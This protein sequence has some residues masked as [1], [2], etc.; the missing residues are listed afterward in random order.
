MI[1]DRLGA[2]PCRCSCRS[3]P[4]DNFRGVVDLIRMKAIYWDD[5]ATRRGIVRG[6]RHPGGMRERQGGREKMIEAA[7]EVDEELMH[8][9]LEGRSSRPTRSARRCARALVCNEIVPRCCGSAFKNKGVQP[10]LDAVVDYLPS[11]L[12]VPPVKGIDESGQEAT[13]ARRRRAVLGARVQD[14]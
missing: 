12:D 14:R 13:R 9:Y 6:P 4:E 5:E 2:N 11:P 8:A 1:R 3:A 7:A 10:L